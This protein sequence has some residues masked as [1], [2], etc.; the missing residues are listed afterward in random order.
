VAAFARNNIATTVTMKTTADS[1]G[2]QGTGPMSARD[3][4]LTQD[5]IE[6][7]ALF[8]VLL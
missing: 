6:L 5:H 4:T 3:S 8:A 1:G 7:E 2:L